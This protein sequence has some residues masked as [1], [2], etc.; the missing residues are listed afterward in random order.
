MP[1]GRR[2]TVK[3]CSVQNKKRLFKAAYKAKSS[4]KQRRKM[5]RGRKKKK[6]RS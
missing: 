2:Y 5:L 1:P 6:G 4:T 3:G